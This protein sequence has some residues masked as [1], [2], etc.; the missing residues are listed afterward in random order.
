MV[1]TKKGAPF[2]NTVAY[3]DDL[4]HHEKDSQNFVGRQL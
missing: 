2:F 3:K 1:V 4:R